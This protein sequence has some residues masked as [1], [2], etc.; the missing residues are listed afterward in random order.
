MKT[1][2][3]SLRNLKAHEFNTTFRKLGPDENSWIN[4]YEELGKIQ[5]EAIESSIK[6]AAR[7]VLA[8]FLVSSL[9]T[10]ELISINILNLSISAPASFFLSATSFIFL[11]TALSFN[12]LSTAMFLKVRQ[13]ARPQIVGFSST[14]FG[15]IRGH[16]QNSL[17]IPSHNNHFLREVFPL[18]SIVGTLFL[19]LALSPL[20][21]IAAIGAYFA[22]LQCDLLLD[23]TLSIVDRI[24][25]GLG[26]ANIAFSFLFV[27][28][29]HT[30]LPHRKRTR[31]I[32]YF[33]LP[34][35][36]LFWPHPREQAWRSD[37]DTDK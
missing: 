4:K 36:C 19:I 5:N 11:I 12:H 15:M 25:S 27:L 33:V 24:A 37:A 30:P 2:W 28:I 3:V 18:T 34:R 9:K 13:G 8:Y 16:D 22:L 7:I 17:G 1:K 29:F 32:R 26:L 21:P 6:A 20:L 31:F 35:L 23:P 10:G 14:T